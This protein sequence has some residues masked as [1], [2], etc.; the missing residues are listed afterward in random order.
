MGELVQSVDTLVIAHGIAQFERD[1]QPAF[2]KR[3]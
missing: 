3:M 2:G 1:H